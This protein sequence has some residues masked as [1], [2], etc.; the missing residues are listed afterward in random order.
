MVAL[1]RRRCF[2]FHYREAVMTTTATRPESVQAEA[3]SPTT[4]DTPKQDTGGRDAGGRFTKGNAGGPGNPFA[5]RVARLRSVMLAC[6]TDEDM[7]VITEMLI[8]LARTGDLAAIK[9]YYE[10]VVGKPRPAVD[11]DTVDYQEFELYCRS[12]HGQQLQELLRER[13]PA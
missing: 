7:K 9:L 8:V 2:P 6:S 1:F 12:P 3:G 5:R 13:V 11:P 4:G 10:Y